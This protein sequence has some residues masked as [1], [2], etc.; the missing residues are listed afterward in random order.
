MMF[1]R[2]VLTV[3]RVPFVPSSEGAII[4]GRQKASLGKLDEISGP[5]RILFALD[6]HGERAVLQF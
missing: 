5:W 2:A 1:L 3:I 4:T 6:T